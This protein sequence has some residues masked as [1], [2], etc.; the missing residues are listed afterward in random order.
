MDVPQGEVVCGQRSW[1]FL[2]QSILSLRIMTFLK[3][4]TSWGLA[5]K[6]KACSFLLAAEEPTEWTLCLEERCD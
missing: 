1:E 5:S 2:S 3:D 4:C 6:R